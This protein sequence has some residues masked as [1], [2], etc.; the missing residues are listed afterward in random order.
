MSTPADRL[1]PHAGRRIALSPSVAPLLRRVVLAVAL[2]TL[3]FGSAA[4]A[5]DRA[6]ERPSQ[7]AVEI[8]LNGERLGRGLVVV[9]QGREEAWLRVGDLRNAVDGSTTGDRLQTWGQELHAAAAGGCATCRYQVVRQVVIS[10]RVRLR[11][12]QPYVPL[13]D[14]ARA[15]EAKVSQDP[16]ASVIHLHVGECR[17]CILEPRPMPASVKSGAEVQPPP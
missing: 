17:W 10:R 9:E 1:E 7:R 16:D 13:E 12:G 8:R 11:A 5:Q 3:A 2:P 6:V 4:A 15:F 14:V